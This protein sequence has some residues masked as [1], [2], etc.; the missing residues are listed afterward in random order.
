MQIS[1]T[2]AKISEAT[3]MKL[4]CFNFVIAFLNLLLYLSIRCL[5]ASLKVI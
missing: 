2:A 5:F 4:A 3:E 1:R